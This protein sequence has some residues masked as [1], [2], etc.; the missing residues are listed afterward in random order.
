MIPAPT[1]TE[2][3]ARGT[4]A[5][6]ANGEVSIR[7]PRR[8]PGQPCIVS[9]LIAAIPANSDNVLRDT[10]ERVVAA[11]GW[12]T[13]DVGQPYVVQQGT[14]AFYSVG[15]GLGGGG[16]GKISP[17]ASGSRQTIASPIE[18]RDV[19]ARGTLQFIPVL[20]AGLRM[21]L[22]AR[23]SDGFNYYYL[24]GIIGA[25]GTVTDIQLNKNV[26]GT[27]T[28][29]ATLTLPTA[30]AAPVFVRLDCV[31][32]LIS[33]SMW[34]T[35]EPVSPMVSV[36][37]FELPGPGGV[38]AFLDFNAADT[39]TGEFDNFLAGSATIPPVWDAYV[40]S[41]EQ[42]INL[43]DSSI[44]PVDRWIPQIVNGQRLNPGEDLIVNGREGTVG[45]QAVVTCSFVYST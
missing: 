35:S 41:T 34:T 37:D 8:R 5:I 23:Q 20:A 31:G 29:L 16:V 38:G 2:E 12:G 42:L 24:V 45:T 30:L 22:T 19:T 44:V 43:V 10:F 18:L 25:A 15:V 17:V 1:R 28:T 27:A 39:D 14:A 9:R 11:G 32:S 33:G 36:I 3:R 7:L 6:D 21:G 13:P 40:D 4:A 26:A